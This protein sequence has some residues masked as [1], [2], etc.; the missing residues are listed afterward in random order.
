M[1]YDALDG[2]QQRY[3]VARRN[4][5]ARKIQAAY[6]RAHYDPAHLIGKRRLLREFEQLKSTLPAPARQNARQNAAKPNAPKTRKASQAPKNKMK[7]F[8]KI[9]ALFRRR[10]A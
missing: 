5:A 6:L 3:E 1:L 9:G 4:S 8:G 10:K 2:M 7:R